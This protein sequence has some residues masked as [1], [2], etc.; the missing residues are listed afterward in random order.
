[1]SDRD[2]NLYDEHGHTNPLMRASEFCAAFNDWARA[3]GEALADPDVSD[4]EKDQLRPIHEHL[5][6]LHIPIR[7]SNYLW[8]R[9]YLRQDHRDKKCP[10][11]KGRWSGY[12]T[13]PVEEM[14]QDPDNPRILLFDPV[15]ECQVGYDL[16][17]WLPNE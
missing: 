3:I 15:C 11:H 13:P 12:E 7:K 14:R 2:P 5:A 8:R 6:A 9:I 16:T 10:K 1:V 17:G 4:Y